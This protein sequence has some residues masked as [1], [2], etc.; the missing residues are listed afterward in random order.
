MRACIAGGEIFDLL[1]KH[2]KITGSLNYQDQ[3]GTTA[4][5]TAWRN[6][7]AIGLWRLLEAGA[8][9]TIAY[10]GKFP[11]PTTPE[12]AECD[13]LLKVRS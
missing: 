13:T 9:P 7:N 3:N 1:F 8:D 5:G 4:A 12:R 6:G 11:S 2:P 10:R